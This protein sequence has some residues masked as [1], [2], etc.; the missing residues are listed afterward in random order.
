M[1]HIN[2]NSVYEFWLVAKHHSFTDAA[3]A[4][5][6]GSV[7]ALHKRVR[8]LEN[9]ENLDLPLLR[10]R[11]TKG[12]DLTESGRRIFAMVAPMFGDFDRLADELRGEDSGPLYLSATAFSSSNYLPEFVS[13]FSPKFP[14]VSIHLS[15]GEESQVIA[16]LESGKADFGVCS[17][18]V[19]PSSC[20]VKAS[21]SMQVG[22]AVPPGHRLSRGVASWSD[23]L[24]E[25]LVLPER[26]SAV[27]RAF[28]DLMHHKKLSGKINIKAEVTTPELSLHAVSA[29]LGVA[30]LAIGPHLNLQNL[31]LTA[32]PSGMPVMRLCLL[33][34]RDR[35]LSKYMR[36][37]TESAKCV[38]R[39]STQLLQKRKQIGL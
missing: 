17:P 7:Q 6:F 29:G 13:A 9:S 5:P 36:Y 30:L 25:P 34:R 21:V 23:L 35:Y 27:R 26:T 4:L 24:Q 38:F 22:I 1:R 8:V 19:L 14:H 10:S 2:W 16:M 31:I 39:E 15:L 28:E 20:E 37:F 32:P 3:R 12:V 18:I 11:G 33:C